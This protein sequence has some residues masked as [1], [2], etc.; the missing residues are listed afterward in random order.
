MD[1]KWKNVRGN[2]GACSK[3]LLANREMQRKIAGKIR[4]SSKAAVTSGKQ[5]SASCNFFCGIQNTK[6]KQ[7]RTFWTGRP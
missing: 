6:I 3:F 1:D 7:G 5:I 4:N 2:A